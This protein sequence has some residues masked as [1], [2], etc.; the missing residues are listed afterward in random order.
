MSCLIRPSILRFPETIYAQ[1]ASPLHQ[2]LSIVILDSTMAI[3]KIPSYEGTCSRNYHKES[4]RERIGLV[5]DYLL[6]TP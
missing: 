3:L 2:R 5:V 6:E 1:G 4:Q